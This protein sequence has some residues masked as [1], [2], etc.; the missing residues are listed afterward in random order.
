MITAVR[1]EHIRE[2]KSA[3]LKGDILRSRKLDKI[4]VASFSENILK[5]F[6]RLSEK[7]KIKFSPH[8]FHISEI[9]QRLKIK[10]KLITNILSEGKILKGREWI[11][12]LQTPS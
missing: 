3:A 7:T 5:D 12:S 6:F 1:P 9:Y 2:I 10:D 11:E 8:L 4:K